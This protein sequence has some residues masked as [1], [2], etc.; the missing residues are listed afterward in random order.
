MRSAYPLGSVT[1]AGGGG[2]VA[3]L[4]AVYPPRADV[5]AAADF[6]T[7]QFGA[8][9]GA[10]TLTDVGDDGAGNPVAMRAVVGASSTDYGFARIPL[11]AAVGGVG[12]TYRARIGMVAVGADIDAT[13]AARA[14]LCMVMGLTNADQWFGVGADVN[15][16]PDAWTI[17]G[18]SG[19]NWGTALAGNLSSAQAFFEFVLWIHRYH[20]GATWTIKVYVSTVGGSIIAADT[21]T[22][23]VNGDAGLV[24]LRLK[25]GATNHYVIV[26]EFGPVIMSG[27]PA[28]PD[29][30][31]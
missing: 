27:E 28:F 5:P 23:G 20:N 15:A 31:P 11:P 21:W 22:A 14:M 6:T 3:S 17:G 24:G 13:T 25:S 7:A 19:G 16:T 4:P 9:D 12:Q 29:G 10:V 2:G 18:A 26:H 1:G 30:D 8:T